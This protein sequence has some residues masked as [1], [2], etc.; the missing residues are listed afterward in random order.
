MIADTAVQVLLNL[1]DDDSAAGRDV[2]SSTAE[3]IA[4]ILVSTRTFIGKK[5]SSHVHF[6]SVDIAEHARVPGGSNG[7]PSSGIP[8]GLGWKCVFVHKTSIDN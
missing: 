1:G 4:P 8:L 6:G 7:V 2:D 5:K 3:K